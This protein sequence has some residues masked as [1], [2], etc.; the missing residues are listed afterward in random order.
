MHM[1]CWGSD[2]SLHRR[3]FSTALAPLLCF[4]FGGQQTCLGWLTR[5]HLQLWIYLCSALQCCTSLWFHYHTQGDQ[6]WLNQ[7]NQIGRFQ[8]Q[9]LSKHKWTQFTYDYLWF[10]GGARAGGLLHSGESHGRGQ[11]PKDSQ[12]TIAIIVWDAQIN[13]R[14]TGWCFKQARF[15]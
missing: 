10:Q 9:H 13:L 5:R 7:S 2:M 1:K 12:Q 11:V 6:V 3:H 14:S 4:V 8:Y 15:K